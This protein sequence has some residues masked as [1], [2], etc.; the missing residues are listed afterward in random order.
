MGL[1]SFKITK[2]KAL[3]YAECSAVPKIMVIAGPNGV[4]KSTLLYAIKRMPSPV[5]VQF[6]GRVLYISPQRVWRKQQIHFNNLWDQTRSYGEALCQDT[7]QPIGGIRIFDAERGPNSADESQ[8]ALK[9]SLSQVEARKQA[10][11]NSV[12]ES[13]GRVTKESIGDVYEPLRDLTR[14]LLPHLLF[15]R[16]DL[17]Q[18]NDVRCLWMRVDDSQKLEI[19]I[20]NLSSGERAVIALFM[21]FVEKQIAQRLHAFQSGPIPAQQEDMTVLIDEPEIHLH[22]LLQTK[23][24]EYLREVVSRGGTQFVVATHSASIL[25]EAFHDEL[26]VL[27][28]PRRTVVNQLVRP[29]TSGERLDAVRELCGDTHVLT[30]CRKILCV[31][32]IASKVAGGRSC[33]VGLFSLLYPGIQ[34][35]VV[36]PCGGKNNVLATTR[37]LRASLDGLAAVTDVLALTDADQESAAAVEPWEIRLPVCMIE[38][39]LLSPG[40]IC[41]Y[42]RSLPG[43]NP[44]GDES[45]VREEL[46]KIAIELRNKEVQRR[47]L[48]M[49][50][51]T[52]IEPRGDTYDELF[53]GFKAAYDEAVRALPPREV[54][55]GWCR[56]AEKEVQGIIDRGAQLERF[57]GK[58]IA[59]KFHEKFINP[60]ASYHTFLMQMAAR[61]GEDAS[62]VNHLRDLMEPHLSV[63]FTTVPG[64]A[65]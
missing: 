52:K 18:H 3:Q 51:V 35:A 17:G 59:K 56:A 15:S 54:F 23:F 64:V 13:T 12:L 27:S 28:P 21:P 53:E 62:A 16:I 46:H 45:A 24:L 42:L 19:D 26:F 48:R 38:N 33:D 31:E 47:V 34:R 65:R 8:S 60:H 61:I 44:L 57:H 2:Q 39:L 6:T 58:T 25:N 22:P 29:A 20:D 30:S 43:E 10:A 9:Y 1:T 49:L 37:E 36:V 55:E 41:Q 40:H 50:K 14:F 11:V 7:I 32:G 4:G 63:G 5:Q